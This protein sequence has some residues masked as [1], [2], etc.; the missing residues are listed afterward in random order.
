MSEMGDVSAGSGGRAD[1]P[2]NNGQPSVAGDQ[3]ASAP[4]ES[5]PGVATL[6]DGPPPAAGATKPAEPGKA[7]E[8]AGTAAPQAAGA[9]SR[10]NRGK[11]TAP[12]RP[13]GD[14]HWGGFPR[15]K[16]ENTSD[17]RR[18]RRPVWPRRGGVIR[19]SNASSSNVDLV[20][21]PGADGCIPG[22]V[23]LGLGASAV[24]AHVGGD[25]F[26]LPGVDAV[27]GTIRTK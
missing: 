21:G 8:S 17:S 24:L 12:A 22:K 23:A 15:K 26:A 13:H 9:R 19:E 20:T 14:W 6:R 10:R 5:Y 25:H 2:S 16:G 27:I 4:E 3:I 11:A 18:G 1:A 7:T